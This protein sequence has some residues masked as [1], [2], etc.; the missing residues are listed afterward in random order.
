MAT[1]HTTTIRASMTAYSTAV[2]P[3]SACRNF[4]T[5]AMNLSIVC[6]FLGGAGGRIA[7]PGGCLGG[8]A[9]GLADGVEG[10]VRRRAQGGDG[11]EA[12]HHDQGEHDRVL[13][14]GRAVL[15]FEEL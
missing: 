15:G 12:H 5:G 14:G 8:A 6:S 10:L 4:T 3:S 11:D 13:D 7:R 2:G 9:D 1:R